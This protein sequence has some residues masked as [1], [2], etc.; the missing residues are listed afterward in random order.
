MTHGERLPRIKQKLDFIEKHK[1]KWY[2]RDE[3]RLKGYELDLDGQIHRIDKKAA[4]PGPFQPFH[5]KNEPE[6]IRAAERGR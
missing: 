1:P 6:G 3:E 4:K 2:R 5:A